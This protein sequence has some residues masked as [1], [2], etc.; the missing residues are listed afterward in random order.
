MPGAT[1]LIIEDNPLNRELAADILDAAGY[2]ILQAADAEEGM[3]LA[4]A[5]RPSLI[6]MDVSLPGID[7]LQATGLLKQ[8][9]ATK[10]IPVLALTAHAL[11]GDEE[12]ALAAGCDGYI[13]KPINTRALPHAV[14]RFLQPYSAMSAR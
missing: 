3:A 9:A 8:E 10:A 5:E 12:R 2:A 14:A 13:P 6:L 11:K 1:I 7:G 4:R